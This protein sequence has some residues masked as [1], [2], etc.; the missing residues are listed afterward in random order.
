[1]VVLE[2]GK[3]FCNHVYLYKNIDGYEYVECVFCGRKKI[4]GVDID[5]V[6]TDDIV[7]Y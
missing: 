6:S 2:S 5:N 4:A 1:M 3:D 7:L